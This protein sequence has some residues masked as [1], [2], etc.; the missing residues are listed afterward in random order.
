MR[1]QA[2]KRLAK[3]SYKKYCETLYAAAERD[4]KPNVRKIRSKEEFRAV[5]AKM[6][7][8]GA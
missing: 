3:W 1:S 8:A 5:Y 4:K 2:Q 6:K 7:G